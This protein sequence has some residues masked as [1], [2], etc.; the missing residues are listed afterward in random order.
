[1]RC[2]SR[3]SHGLG[4]QNGEGASQDSLTED[5]G[6]SLMGAIAAAILVVL[7]AIPFYLAA[8]TQGVCNGSVA[9]IW[10]GVGFIVI[11]LAIAVL[12]ALKSAAIFL[13]LALCLMGYGW[14]VAHT[15]N[16]PLSFPI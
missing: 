15:G 14:Y 5:D 4:E 16:C 9:L 3:L 7:S 13:V 12:P 10:F 6:P 11:A 1:M 2:D 8:T